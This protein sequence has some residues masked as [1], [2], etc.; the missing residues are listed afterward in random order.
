M[1]A[2]SI[3]A[4]LSGQSWLQTV[5]VAL[6]IA[7]LKSL[8][9]HCLTTYKSMIIV[10]ATQAGQT[11]SYPDSLIAVTTVIHDLVI[12]T[13]NMSDFFGYYRK[14]SEPMARVSFFQVPRTVE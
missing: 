11:L 5:D 2:K 1:Q 7:A 8:Q 6:P 3:V 13:Q 12:V 4:L 9:R 10:K 14:S